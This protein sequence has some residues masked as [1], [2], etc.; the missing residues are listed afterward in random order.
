MS[1][2]DCID[3]VNYPQADVLANEGEY[4]GNSLSSDSGHQHPTSGL[5]VYVS[6]ADIAGNTTRYVGATAGGA[7]P[8]ET[9]G[10]LQT[11]DFAVDQLAGM[12]WVLTQSGSWLGPWM[13]GDIKQTAALVVPAGWLVCDGSAQLDSD[14]PNLFS[15]L[16]IELS[17]V[18]VHNGSATV[19]VSSTTG[20]VVGMPVYSASTWPDTT[21]VIATG[22]TVHSVNSGVSIELS[23]APSDPGGPPTTTATLYIAPWGYDT[24]HSL[25][26]LPDLQG[27]F[28]IGANSTYPLGATG[29]GSGVITHTHSIT[30]LSHDHSGSGSGLESGEESAEHIHHDS[31]HN[32]YTSQE[33]ISNEN[34]TGSG[35]NPVNYVGPDGTY[36]TVIGY[37]VI[38]TESE[39][40]VHYTPIPDDLAGT[41]TANAPS[42]AVDSV[43][44]PYSA[45]Q[46]IIKT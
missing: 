8:A 14:Y 19:D 33:V 13:P 18:T 3:Y 40:H 27:A 38:G 16:V 37:A 12:N 35:Y 34:F 26:K 28:P 45:V 9:G 15:A 5:P 21:E 43:L 20:I 4:G 23:T 22:T 2:T 32:H 39:P 44:P 29:D 42:G 6:D 25:F 30:D 1:C 10:D 46:Y 36:T 41:Y 24:T 11:G 31:G 7:Y 17:G